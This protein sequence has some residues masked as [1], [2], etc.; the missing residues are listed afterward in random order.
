MSKKRKIPMSCLG[1]RALEQIRAA[2]YDVDRQI[3]RERSGSRKLAGAPMS[4][5]SRD[6]KYGVSKK[7]DRTLDGIVFDSKLEMNAYRYLRD[8]GVAFERQIPFVLM[9]GFEHEGK[10]VQPIRYVCDFQV[11][12]LDGTSFIV[13]TK[14]VITPDC[15]LK[16]KLMLSLGHKVHCVGSVAA[17]AAFLHEHNCIP[18]THGKTAS[19]TSTSGSRVPAQIPVAGAQEA[20]A[21]GRR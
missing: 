10:K 18:V 7:D 5:L 17:L 19:P 3:A 4:F 15:R 14:G 12:S 21:Q 13:D 16:L 2:G 1:P 9:E 11:K 6:S 8:L 20:S